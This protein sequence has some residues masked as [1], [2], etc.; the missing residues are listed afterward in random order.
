MCACASSTAD[1]E[2]NTGSRFPGSPAAA[3]A[4]DTHVSESELALPAIKPINALGAEG[5]AF[6]VPIYVYLY[7]YVRMPI[8]FS[9]YCHF[10]R[11]TWS[12]DDNA[13]NHAASFFFFPV[14][15]SLSHAEALDNVRTLAKVL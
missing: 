14:T 3:A 6:A 9:R 7:M 1:N 10:R 2:I 12:R 13:I 5:I 11:V 4:G 8:S 15:Y